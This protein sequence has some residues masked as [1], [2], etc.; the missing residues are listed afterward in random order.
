MRP[1]ELTY[2]QIYLSVNPKRR[3][4]PK[5]ERLKASKKTAQK[6]ELCQNFWILS[7]YDLIIQALTRLYNLSVSLVIKQKIFYPH[8]I[9]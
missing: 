3:A 8:D 9:F 5:R 7:L 6:F 1:Y 2:R 4:L